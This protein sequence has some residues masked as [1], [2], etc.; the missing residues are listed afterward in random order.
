MAWVQ[1]VFAV[2]NS[3]QIR[4]ALQTQKRKKHSQSFMSTDKTL[5]STGLTEDSLALPRVN[6]QQH[7]VR[8]RFSSGHNE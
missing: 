3:L 7:A 4:N 6:L 1:Y 8:H 5:V 2:C